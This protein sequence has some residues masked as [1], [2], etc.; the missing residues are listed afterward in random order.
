MLLL[1]NALVKNDDEERVIRIIRKLHGLGFSLRRICT[2][3]ET[4][5]HLTK[6][7]NLHWHPETEAH[8]LKRGS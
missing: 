4:E 6:R 2:E 7:G 1:L 8:I 3:L 5:G